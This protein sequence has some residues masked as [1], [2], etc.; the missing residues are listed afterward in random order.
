MEGKVKEGKGKGREWS[1]PCPKSASRYNTKRN[2]E[3]VD[4]PEA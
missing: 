3:G 4:V 2:S 1:I